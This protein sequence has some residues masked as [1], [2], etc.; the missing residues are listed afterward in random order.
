[1]SWSIGLLTPISTA[2]A[3]RT[4]VET[5][6]GGSELLPVEVTR[7]SISRSNLGFSAWTSSV[8]LGDKVGQG[9]REEMSGEQSEGACQK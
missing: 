4:L 3:L 9:W 5:W 7:T 2:T 8:Y 6:S 1:M